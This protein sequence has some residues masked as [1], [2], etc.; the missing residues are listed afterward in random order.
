M[1]IRK[2]KRGISRSKV[3]K[4]QDALTMMTLMHFPGIAVN[5]DTSCADCQD[6]RMGDCPGEDRKGFAVLDCMRGK[7]ESGSG[8]FGFIGQPRN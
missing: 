1:A 7:L 4:L 6:Y 8:N 2:L 3:Q 5:D